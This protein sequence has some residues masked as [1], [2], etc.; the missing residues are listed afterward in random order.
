M[1][2]DKL[3]Y[4]KRGFDPNYPLAFMSEYNCF[5]LQTTELS[6]DGT[7]RYCC[8]PNADATYHIG[9]YR[10]AE[11]YIE[12]WSEEHMELVLSMEELDLIGI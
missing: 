12:I 8:N 4:L 1:K 3:L 5:M 11:S 10:K 9:V 2:S 7:P 6:S